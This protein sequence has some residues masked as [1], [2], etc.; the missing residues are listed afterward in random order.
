MVTA[1]R[2]NFDGFVAYHPHR[3]ETEPRDWYT[4][5]F[6]NGI[7]EAVNMEHSSRNQGEDKDLVGL[8]YEVNV[9]RAAS[10]YLK[11]QC[12]MGVGFRPFSCS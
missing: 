1:T 2:Y 4:Q 5:Y 7:I 8:E 3:I 10:G 12:D 9:S 11:I 6:R